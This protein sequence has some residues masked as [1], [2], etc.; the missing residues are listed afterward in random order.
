MISIDVC[1]MKQSDFHLRRFEAFFLTNSLQFSS[2]E[3]LKI[4]KTEIIVIQVFMLRCTLI[5]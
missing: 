4:S 1:S 5:I 3:S 2:V